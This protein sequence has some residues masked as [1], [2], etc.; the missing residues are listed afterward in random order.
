M[1]ET[2]GTTNSVTLPVQ[3]EVAHEFLVKSGVFTRK[4][5]MTIESFGFDMV[6]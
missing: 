5:G 1:R 6:S 4:K 3:P 2:Q